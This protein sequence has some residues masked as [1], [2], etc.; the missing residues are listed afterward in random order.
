MVTSRKK[1]QYRKRY[2]L[3]QHELKRL[4]WEMGLSYNTASGMSC[5][6]VKVFDEMVDL[7]LV[8]I[9]QAV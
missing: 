6:N 5:C 1:L 4:I 8:T 3:L 7:G 9:P 2:E